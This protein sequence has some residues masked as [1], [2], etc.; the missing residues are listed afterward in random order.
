M[1]PFPPDTS[2]TNFEPPRFA[3]LEEQGL[4]RIPE[5]PPTEG[6]APLDPNNPTPQVDATP[7]VQNAVFQ[8][9]AKIDKT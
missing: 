8:D 5:L 1:K 4:S 7:V 9:F 6:F 3:T 2:I